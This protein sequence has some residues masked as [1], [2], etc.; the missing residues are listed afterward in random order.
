M[1]VYLYINF[2]CN[3]ASGIT[4]RLRCSKIAEWAGIDLSTVYRGIAELESAGLFHTKES[5][6]FMGVIPHQG[7]IQ[8]L[9][10]QQG[11]EK[12]ERG[13]YQKLRRRIDEK[14]EG[15]TEPLPFAGVCRLYEALIAERMKEKGFYPQAKGFSHIQEKLDRYAPAED[16]LS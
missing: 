1:K 14:S 3:L 12:K 16:D 7:L 9:A 5:G 4:H 11:Y 15:R 2:N 8:H 10:I 13:F 6:D